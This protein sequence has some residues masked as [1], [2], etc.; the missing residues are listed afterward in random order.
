MRTIPDGVTMAV[1]RC[2]KH[3]DVPPLNTNA[4][5]VECGA[6]VRDERNVALQERLWAAEGREASVSD[7]L[8]SWAREE[9]VAEGC[10]ASEAKW[11]AD[12]LWTALSRR[13]ATLQRVTAEAQSMARAQQRDG[14]QALRLLVNAQAS[15][16]GLWFKAE[17]APEAYL[18]QELR[19]LH[20]AIEGLL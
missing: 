12:R 16:E 11:V 1:P 9:G 8:N 15:D 10:S 14:T 20:A 3:D 4:A 5:G 7:L 6:C 13:V 18:Q 19:R 17:T 2:P